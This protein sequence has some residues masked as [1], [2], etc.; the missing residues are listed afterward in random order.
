ME[1]QNGLSEVSGLAWGVIGF[2][3]LAAL[4]I[5]AFFMS[6]GPNVF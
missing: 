6:S 3:A 2:I 4:L 5:L 1:K